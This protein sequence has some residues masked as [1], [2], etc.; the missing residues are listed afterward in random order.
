MNKERRHTQRYICAAEKIHNRKVVMKR[1]EQKRCKGEV[2]DQKIKE[3]DENVE[4]SKHC[5]QND[6]TLTYKF[7][8]RILT[9]NIEYQTYE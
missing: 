2:R 6:R 8:Q 9:Q 4:G 3:S 1:Y 5:K 7:Y